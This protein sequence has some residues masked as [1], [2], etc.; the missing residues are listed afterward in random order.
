[1]GTLAQL[2]SITPAVAVCWPP[3]HRVCMSAML[4]GDGSQHRE[5][6]ALAKNMKDAMGNMLSTYGHIRSLV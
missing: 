2:N 3:I 6:G 5:G 4:Q 1:M